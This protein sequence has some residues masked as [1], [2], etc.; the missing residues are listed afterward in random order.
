MPVPSNPIPFE[1]KSTS[2]LLTALRLHTAHVPTLTAALDARFGDTPDLFDNDALVLDL[3]LLR[4]GD[5][6][7]DYPSLIAHL[8]RHR[9]LPVAVQGGSVNQMAAALD[10]GLS[11][12]TAPQPQ[13]EARVAGPLDDAE[14][15][16]LAV[17]APLAPAATGRPA[18]AA[19]LSDETL[20]TGWDD[21]V[22]VAPEA[23]TA[24][25]SGTP[26]GAAPTMVIDRPLR[27]GQRVYARGGDLVVLQAVSVGAEVIADGHI[28]VY[29]P[30]RGKAIAGA[31]GNAEARIFALGMAPELIS[32][33]GIY[34]TSE[35]PLPES[36]QG[37]T[38][39][40]RL[41]PG[42]D[43]DKLLIEAIGA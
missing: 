21:T 36:I 13:H 24:A 23:A 26:A 4:A 12:A 30:L 39:Q 25:A 8:R 3:S 16:A 43:G 32:I 38:A 17:D 28:H 11:L 31:R 20:A 34:R 40:V 9:L 35:V 42:P 6:L 19:A 2:W 1:L 14:Q 29:A 22:P 41:V 33:A 5:A 27:S 37:K 10:A 18:A 7:L 15:A